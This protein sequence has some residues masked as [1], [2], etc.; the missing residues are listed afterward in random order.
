[1]SKKQQKELKK[2][3]IFKEYLRDIWQKKLYDKFDQ[4]RA[5]A[6]NYY[7]RKDQKTEYAYILFASIGMI[8]SSE[9]LTDAMLDSIA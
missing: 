3:E 5:F 4:F 2:V 9:E 6:Y 7:S 8:D 1:M